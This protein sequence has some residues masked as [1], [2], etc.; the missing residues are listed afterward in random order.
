M[1][2]WCEGNFEGLGNIRERELL[3]ALTF[4][5]VDPTHIQIV[6][7]PSIQDSPTL[8][9]NETR[10]VQI[11]Q[12]VV[13]KWNIKEVFPSPYSSI[14]FHLWCLRGVGSP[15]PY[16]CTFCSGNLLRKQQHF[17]KIFAICKL[18]YQIFGP[19]SN[20]LRSHISCVVSTHEL[21]SHV[22]APYPISVVSSSVRFVFVLFLC[23]CVEWIVFVCLF[24]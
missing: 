2:D 11:L 13:E 12:S 21:E 3:S 15:E 19:I 4:L 7:D 18:A 1:C 8:A 6:H 9:W 5:S 10:T 23:Q 24:T 16:L 14:D 20:E 17:C 22:F